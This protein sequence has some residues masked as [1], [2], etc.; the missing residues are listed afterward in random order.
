MP[1]RPRSW[2]PRAVALLVGLLLTTWVLPG[3]ALAATDVPKERSKGSRSPAS[4]ASIGSCDYWAYPAAS[5]QYALV[6][7]CLERLPGGV[8]AHFSS[9]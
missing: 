8:R 2:R 4:V 5:G 7:A 3:S 1:H 9:P 6:D